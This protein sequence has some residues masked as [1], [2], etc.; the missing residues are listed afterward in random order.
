[1]LVPKVAVEATVCVRVCEYFEIIYSPPSGLTLDL[2]DI[3]HI[4]HVHF[5]ELPEYLL[6]NH[7]EVQL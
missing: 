1:M 3:L 2:S 5:S 6:Q 4:D 7:I